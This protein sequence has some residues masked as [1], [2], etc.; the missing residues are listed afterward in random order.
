M[1]SCLYEKKRKHPSINIDPSSIA[2]TCSHTVAAYWAEV[3]IKSLRQRPARWL[4][5]QQVLFD[6][7]NFTEYQY[8]TNL[9]QCYT[10]LTGLDKLVNDV[11]MMSNL[12]FSG[13]KKWLDLSQ[14]STIKCC[15]FSTTVHQRATSHL[16]SVS[17]WTSALEKCYLRWLQPVRE[18][19]KASSSSQTYS[20]SLRGNWISETFADHCFR[21]Q[22]SFQV[23]LSCAIHQNEHQLSNTTFRDQRAG[24]N[25][26]IATHDAYLNHNAS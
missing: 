8:N 15:V 26:L 9:I 4:A 3:W 2:A 19:L 1:W 14:M 6:S 16:A 7:I 23:G 12:T 17:V 10:F 21:Y 11:I 25:A 20:S 24:K 22:N 18:H 13:R 5:T